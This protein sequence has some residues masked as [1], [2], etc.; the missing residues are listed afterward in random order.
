M[1]NKLLKNFLIVKKENIFR[2][3]ANSFYEYLLV[4]Y[5]NKEI[6][7]KV[8]EEKQFFCKEYKEKPV[9]ETMP[10]IKVASFLASEGMEDTM[11]RWMHKICNN[12]KSFPVILN[13]YSGFPPDTIYLRV[14]N[15]CPFQQLAKELQIVNTYVSDCSYPPMNFIKKPHVNIAQH[16]SEEVF[17]RALAQYAHKSF[18]E[19]FLAKELIFL[20]RNNGEKNGTPINV[21]GLRPLDG[22]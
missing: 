10:Y 5:P 2:E 4:V 17:S 9:N 22:F 20:K 19:T 3:P 6:Q 7:N 1:L 12:Q 15:N 8:Q 18:H 11:I 14:Q 13:N 21:F 16:L